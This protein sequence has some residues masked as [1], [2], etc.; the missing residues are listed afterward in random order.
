MV[1]NFP[2]FL[3]SLSSSLQDAGAQNERRVNEEHFSKLMAINPEF[4]MKYQQGIGDI[5]ASGVQEDERRRQ[6]AQQESVR[7]ALAELG[8]TPN[9]NPQSG[10]AKLSAVTGDPSYLESLYKA[11]SG[12]GSSAGERTIAQ[13]MQ[14]NPEM[15]YMDALEYVKSARVRGEL[16]V[17]DEMANAAGEESY[18]K[19]TRELEARSALEPALEADITTAKMEASGEIS[20]R[21]KKEM[22]AQ[23]VLSIL[24]DAES[25]ISSSTGSAIGTLRDVGK[26]AL[27]ISDK[28]TQANE[29]LKLYSGWL[30]SN[31]P[32]MEGPQSNFD[33]QNYKQMAADLGNTMK[34]VGDRIAALK[35]LRSLQAKYSNLNK[36]DVLQDPLQASQ[37]AIQQQENEIGKNIYQRPSLAGQSNS[38]VKPENTQEIDESLFNAKKALRNGA[39]PEAVKQRLIEAGID[40][41]K[42]GL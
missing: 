1:S 20:D 6:L 21:D 26:S 32:R 40:P 33:V 15:S 38:A 28:Q 24:D 23:Q 18:A 2:Q 16:S 19:K 13:V 4:A 36:K 14:E 31:V 3:Q 7:S 12:V 42:A 22:N 34:P 8:K 5:K 11:Q 37:A 39:S 30:I 10:L 17:S 35:V 29:K 25:L 9:I 41:A 27:G